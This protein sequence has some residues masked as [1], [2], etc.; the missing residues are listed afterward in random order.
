[1]GVPVENRWSKRV[2]RPLPASVFWVLYFHLWCP[3]MV[4]QKY[5]HKNWR[6][7]HY[8]RPCLPIDCVGRRFL[9]CCLRELRTASESGTRPRAF[10]PGPGWNLQCP[11]QLG[12]GGAFPPGLG[13][14]KGGASITPGELGPRAPWVPHQGS[15]QPQPQQQE[16]GYSTA[17]SF[18]LGLSRKLHSKT[19]ALP[20]C[21]RF[22]EM[23]TCHWEAPW[24]PQIWGSTLLTPAFCF[25]E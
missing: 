5:L 6:V 24:P 23:E 16:P 4:G 10:P 9:I 20:T 15:P 25:A 8:Q 1:M 11:Q 12:L 14:D 2:L 7:L 18:T 21:N 19:A 22:L 13:G 3:A 17:P